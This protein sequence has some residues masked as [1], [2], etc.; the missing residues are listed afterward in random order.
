MGLELSVRHAAEFFGFYVCR[1]ILQDITI[2]VN[3]LLKRSTEW[4]LV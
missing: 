3:K 2:L 4:V 1:F